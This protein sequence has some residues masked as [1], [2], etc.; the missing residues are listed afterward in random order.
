MGRYKEDGLIAKEFYVQTF[1]AGRYRKV[2]RYP[3]SLPGDS[4]A[5][6][7]AKHQRS[8]AAQ[9]Y[10]NIRDS[11][12]HLLWLLCC[13]Y[14]HKSAAFL[15]LTFDD[16][17]LPP[18]RVAVKDAV[19]KMIRQLRPVFRNRGDAFPVIYTVEGQPSKALRQADSSWEIA[20][21]KDRRRWDALDEKSEDELQED[22]VR[23]H[24]HMFLLLPQ[25]EDRELVRSFW[26]YGQCY[27]NHIR[28]NEFESFQRLAAY[29]TKES[30]MGIR[31]ENERAYVP[32]LGLIKPSK[33]GHWC[34]ESETIGFPLGSEWLGDGNDRDYT[35]GYETNWIMYRF[36]RPAQPPKPYASKGRISKSQNRRKTK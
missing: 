5:T 6:R 11:T 1:S 9:R 8:A 32:S 13:N 35:T 7:S 25:K 10:I 14:D 17:H 12:E 18:S 19:R 16:A 33:D 24:A 36:P 29:V 26:P 31:P 21:W 2:V 27:I 15:T 4:P 20:P 22:T 28:V 34:E 3:R 23:L 30:R